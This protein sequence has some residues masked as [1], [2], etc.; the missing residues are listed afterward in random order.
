[1]LAFVRLTE[2]ELDELYTLSTQ[3][4]KDTFASQNTAKNM[5]LYLEEHMSKSKL[6]EELTNPDSHFYFAYKDK[7]CIG[8]L[9]LNFNTA[10]KESIAYS[11]PYEVERIYVLKKWQR[12]R[13]G[14]QL[15]EKAIQM[16]KEQDCEHL[17]LGVWEHNTTAIQ[18]YTQWGLVP[19][20]SHNFMLGTDLQ[21]DLLYC[22]NIK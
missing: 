13:F 2:N 9:K 12:K 10:Q 4:F 3:T 21:T 16:G 19:I 5:T 17:W 18:F 7:D 14:T 11:K 8:Y 6:L 20:G 15:F 1:M 22:L